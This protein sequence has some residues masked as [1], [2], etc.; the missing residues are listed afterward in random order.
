MQRE[1]TAVV[2]SGEQ[3]FRHHRKA[4]AHTGESPVFR[5]TAEF[6]SALARAGNLENGMRNLGIGNVGLVCGVE[7]QKRVVFASVIHPARKLLARCHGTR[8]I[9][10][11][12]KIDQIEM[13]VWRRWHETIFRG[14]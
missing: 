2:R 13:L 11:K 14:A 10:W 1:P 6:H 7:Q 9:V 3:I 12:T 4:T 8:W 5:K